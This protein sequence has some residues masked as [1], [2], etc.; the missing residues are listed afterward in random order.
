MAIWFGAA[1]L[2]S[3]R[4]HHL[5]TPIRSVSSGSLYPTVIIG[6]MANNLLP[7]RSG[8]LVRAYILG[9]R[10]KIS[11]VSTLGTITVE[12]LLDVVVLMLFLVAV[13]G[14]SGLN[15]PIGLAAIG[16]GLFSLLLLSTFFLLTLSQELAGRCTGWLENVLPSQ[17]RGKMGGWAHSFLLGIRS[18]RNPQTVIILLA[19]SVAAWA[20]EAT[21][22]FLVGIGFGI[23][24]AFPI[25]LLVTAAANLAIALPSTSGGIGPF[26]FF[27]REALVFVGVSSAVASDYAIALHG[28]LLVPVII[29]GLFLLWATHIPVRQ[30]LN[31]SVPDNPTTHASVG[32]QS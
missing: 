12:R 14:Y 2:R 23:G 17:M 13:A 3:V 22:Y 1:W 4:W 7:F 5:L 25:Y 28:L 18:L 6:Y 8:E 24:E 26:E 10:W 29:V 11:K 31:R 21:A 9:E 20:L 19:T 27:A 32:P 15:H 16:L 30:F